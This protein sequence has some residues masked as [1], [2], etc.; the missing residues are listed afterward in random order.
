MMSLLARMRATRQPVG[1]LLS[2]MFVA[3]WL[4]LALLPCLMAMPAGVAGP[5][6]GCEHCPQPDPSPEGIPGCGAPGGL[7]VAMD[8]GTSGS[9]QAPVHEA[10]PDLAPPIASTVA[11]FPVVPAR[12]IGPPF[13][14]APPDSHPIYLVNCALLN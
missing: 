5:A 2:A 7:C 9:A 8:T 3:V 6:A 14:V 1:R 11:P 12:D 13:I 4:N 10:Q